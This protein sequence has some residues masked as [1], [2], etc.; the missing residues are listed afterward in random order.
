M[1]M[2][3]VVAV[4]VVLDNDDNSENVDITTNV[5]LSSSLLC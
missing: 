4:A 5:C 2:A 1:M 3:V